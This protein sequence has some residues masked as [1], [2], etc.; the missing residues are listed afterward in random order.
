MNDDAIIRQRI[1][2]R[3][4]RAIAMQIVDEATPKDI[5]TDRIESVLAEF[6]ARK[7]DEPTTH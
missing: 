3:S 1:G 6:C 4:V 5:S 7:R 2:G